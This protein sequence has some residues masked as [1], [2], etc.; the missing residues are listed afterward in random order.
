AIH[1]QV[2]V[3]PC[4]RPQRERAVEQNLARSGF[5][6]V[7]AAHYFGDGHCR[8]VGYAGKLIAGQAIAPPHDEIAEI[9]AGDEAL[10]SQVGIR[11]LYRFAIGYE[12]SP[13][14]SV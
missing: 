12:E 10:R 7:R 4:G 14:D 8:I 11:K 13:V 3:E 9:D 2:A 6:Q 5:E 1:D